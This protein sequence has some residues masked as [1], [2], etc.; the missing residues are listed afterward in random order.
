MMKTQDDAGDKNKLIQQLTKE[1][2]G[3]EHIQQLLDTLA[4]QPGE[5]LVDAGCGYGDRTM[6]IAA[7]VLPNGH[8][9]GFDTNNERLAAANEKIIAHQMQQ[10]VSAEYTD[11]RT[12]P[13]PD[14]CADAWYCR[15]M[16]EYLAD[17]IPAVQEAMRVVKP[18]GRIVTI[19]ADWDSLAYNIADKELE[20][21]FVAINSDHGGGSS[22]NGRIGRQLLPAFRKAGLVDVKLQACVGWCD[23]Y[24]Q[25]PLCH[26]LGDG[27]VN[28]G[29][30]IREE[31]DR[32]YAELAAQAAKDEYFRYYTYFICQGRVPE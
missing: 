31:L 7:H 9:Y 24:I 27:A 3:L 18:G 17:P 5:V 14:N 30:I 2:H 11:I 29:F 10:V 22:L 6:L 21:R 25:D 28:H 13:L 19:E 8:V 26:P 12:L 15:E 4:P 32:F 1:L 23:S 16:L 20:R